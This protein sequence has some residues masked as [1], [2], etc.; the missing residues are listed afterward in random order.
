MSLIVMKVEK[1]LG[2]DDVSLVVEARGLVTEIVSMCT[3]YS[4]SFGDGGIYQDFLRCFAPKSIPSVSGL[5]LGFGIS[6]NTTP[7]EKPF[8]HDECQRSCKRFFV[9]FFIPQNI[10]KP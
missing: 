3:S 2:V 10:S 9:C 6:E 8:D 7:S 5:S 4:I 1:S